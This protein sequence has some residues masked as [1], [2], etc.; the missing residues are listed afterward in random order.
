M[1]SLAIEGNWQLKSIAHLWSIGLSLEGPSSK[2]GILICSCIPS[3]MSMGKGNGK[4]AAQMHFDENELILTPEPV[5]RRRSGEGYPVPGN[6]QAIHAWQY[7]RVDV[8]NNNS[9]HYGSL[10]APVTPKAPG[11]PLHYG[12]LDDEL[13]VTP[14]ARHSSRRWMRSPLSDDATTS[15][16]PSLGG[17]GEKHIMRAAADEGLTLEVQNSMSFPILEDNDATQSTQ[18]QSESSSQKRSFE[19]AQ[20]SSSSSATI[21]NKSQKTTRATDL[22]AF[23]RTAPKKWVWEC[24]TKNWS[25]QGCDYLRVDCFIFE[26]PYAAP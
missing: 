1:L 7:L 2:V 4:N 15:T 16:T 24:W 21:P 22:H 17:S 26:A 25:N 10:P 12:N 8:N 3:K 14:P 13:L 5:R 11:R 19:D 20:S 9:T 6:P 18:S 23:F